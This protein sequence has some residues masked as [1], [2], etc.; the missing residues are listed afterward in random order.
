[1]SSEGVGTP[2]PPEEEYWP[3]TMAVPLL[4][5]IEELVYRETTERPFFGFDG[6][7]HAEEGREIVYPPPTEA[8]QEA[9]RLIKVLL[10]DV[11]DA[12]Y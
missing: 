3:I 6:L 1:M 2:T 5:K 10:N 9:L 8:G 11:Q 12:L 4:Q 7:D